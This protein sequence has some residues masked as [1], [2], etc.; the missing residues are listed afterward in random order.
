M[1]MGMKWWRRR[2]S[3][4]GPEARNLSVYTCSLYT[5]VT[6]L[7]PTGRLASG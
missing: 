1:N 2:E 3:N 5:R 6:G 4:P 7:A